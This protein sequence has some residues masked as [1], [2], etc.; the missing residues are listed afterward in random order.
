MYLCEK[1]PTSYR[2]LVETYHIEQLWIKIKLMGTDQLV[3]GCLYKSPSASP[4]ESIDEI[5]NLFQIVY[6]LNPSHLLICGDFKI[7]QIDCLLFQHLLYP[8]MS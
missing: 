4:V 2:G 6:E 1:Q 5:A 3:A 7:P 8:T